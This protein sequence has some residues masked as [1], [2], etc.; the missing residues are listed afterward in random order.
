MQ[1]EAHKNT[2]VW[3]RLAL[4]LV[5][6]LGSLAAAP[7]T[8]SADVFISEYVEGTVNNKALEI[9]NGTPVPLDLGAGGYAIRIYSNGNS[10][11][12]ATLNLS[13]IVAA[14]DVQVI[15]NNSATAPALIAVADVSTT[16]GVLGF[17]GN[18]ALE[19][20]ANGTVLDVIGQIGFDPVVEWGTAP[21][22]T[23]DQTLRR[24]GTLTTGDPVGTD[25]F[26]PATQWDGFV[27]DDFS[28]LGM[29]T[30]TADGDGDSVPDP[31]D[32]CPSVAN[33]TQDNY[34]G[35]TPGDLC[36]VDDD[37]DGVTDG[38]DICSQGMIG[39]GGDNDSDGCKD[40]E[41]VDDD[42]DAVE[43]GFDNCQLVANAD[44]VDFDI[45]HAGDVC[46]T[47]DD[48]DGLADGNDSCAKG[49]TGTGGD[50]DGDGCKAAED[51]DDD[52]DG[53][54]DTQDACDLLAGTGSGCPTSTRSLSLKRVSRRKVKG[55]LAAPQIPA[56]RAGQKI[57]L[58]RITRSGARKVRSATTPASGAFAFGAL[59]PGRY[60]VK[61]SSRLI[62]DL[63]SCAAA[64]SKTVRLR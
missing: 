50:L 54:F 21:T 62:P 63:G 36:D 60:F 59:K 28:G 44:Q 7:G 49:A 38:T 30:V 51:T 34:D 39:L 61:A 2:R 64:K 52:G 55:T 26:D 53:V 35:D 24:K 9:Y 13:G 33:P 29:H 37:N 42:N 19:L 45:D 4:L 32:N 56:C 12:G 17:N 22:S 41:D 57:S 20:V 8:A 5:G 46:D 31:T 40:G 43:D 3:S 14:G 6:V 47:D 25:A 15:R 58:M 11:A 27:M 10:V 48:N 23:Q 1:Q 16:N 18:D